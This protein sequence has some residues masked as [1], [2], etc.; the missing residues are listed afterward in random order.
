MVLKDE[1]YPL[2]FENGDFKFSVKQCWQ[3]F[4]FGG[5]SMFIA[6]KQGF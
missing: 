1:P 2:L 4:Q 5:N 3:S 6:W